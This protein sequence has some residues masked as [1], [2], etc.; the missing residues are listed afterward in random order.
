MALVELLVAGVEGLGAAV[1]V[2][3]MFGT[4]DGV[5]KLGA[6]LALLLLV[7]AT[8][9]SPFLPALGWSAVTGTVAAVTVMR[10]QQAD[11]PIPAPTSSSTGTG[12]PSI[13]A[14]PDPIDVSDLDRLDDF[15]CNRP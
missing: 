15:A 11:S 3:W 13:A 9:R 6:G 2:G 5:K 14:S 7:A 10:E 12:G 8:S 1:F 4:P